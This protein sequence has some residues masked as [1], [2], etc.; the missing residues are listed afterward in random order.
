MVLALVIGASVS[1]AALIVLSIALSRMQQA[2]FASYQANRIVVL[3]KQ[4]YDPAEQAA[5]ERDQGGEEAQRP[6]NIWYAP[7]LSPFKL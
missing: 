1:I 7:W 5:I 6:P 2:L 3:R 4:G